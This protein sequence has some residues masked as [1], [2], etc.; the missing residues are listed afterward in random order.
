MSTTFL[1]PL[2]AAVALLAGCNHRDDEAAPASGAA[3]TPADP[4]APPSDTAIP[5]DT[6]PPGEAPPPTTPP[7]GG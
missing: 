5:T 3:T 7:P 1:I 4:A 2:W 6:P